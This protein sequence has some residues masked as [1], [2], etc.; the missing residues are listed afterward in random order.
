MKRNM[1]E[2][3]FDKILVLGKVS[4]VINVFIQTEFCEMFSVTARSTVHFYKY[5][6]KYSNSNDKIRSHVY[7]SSL[8]FFNK[9]NRS[10]ENKTIRWTKQLPPK[11]TEGAKWENFHQAMWCDDVNF[12]LSFSSPKMIGNL[13]YWIYL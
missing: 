5:Y 10:A 3:Y 4:L 12:H 8:S 6:Y 2:H 13:R 11:T 7:Q 1:E 9:S